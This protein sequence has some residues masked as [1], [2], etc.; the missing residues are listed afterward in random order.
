MPLTLCSNMKIDA[1]SMMST[2]CTLCYCRPS[3][4]YTE[5]EAKNEKRSTVAIHLIMPM[6]INSLKESANPRESVRE[7]P[8]HALSGHQVV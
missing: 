7:R 4:D 5:L 1:F 2:Q 6:F 3:Y 8:L